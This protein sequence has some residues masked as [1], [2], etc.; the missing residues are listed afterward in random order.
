[1]NQ[2]QAQVQGALASLWKISG[3]REK[4]LFTLL[5]V[6]IY[7]FGVHVPMP[8]VDHE[9]LT[10]LFGAGNVL[11]GF[12]DL[13][14]GGAL[15]KFSVFALGITPYINASI[16]MQLMTSVIPKLEEL[17]K[18]GGEAGRKKIQ[19]WTRYFTIVLAAI[20]AIGIS[21]W[22]WASGVVLEHVPGKDPFPFMFFAANLVT[23]VAGTVFIMWLGELITE[24]GI[25]NGASLLIMISI[26]AAMPTYFNQ[27]AEGVSA[28][29]Y[30]WFQVGILAAAFLAILVAI[31]IVQEG[32]RRI[33]VQAAKRQ[34]G[35][36][37]HQGRMSYIPFKINQGGVMPIIFASSLML[38]PLTVSSWMGGAKPKLVPVDWQFWTAPAWNLDN[39][40]N[41]LVAALNGLMTAISTSGFVYNFLFFLLII[42]FTYF[43]ASLVL[44]PAEL[45]NNLKKY[46]NFIPG[47]RPGKPTAEFLEQVLNRITFLG[48]I[49]LGAVAIL[50]DIVGRATGILTFQGLGGTA[51]LIMVGVAIDLYNQLQTQLLSRQYEGF[52]K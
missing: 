2:A 52:M 40:K 28:G 21:N 50:P 5:M 51:L 17:Q 15:A 6:A 31:V 29:S 47:Y 1:M 36:R 23:L 27:T 13:F 41:A 44:N 10:G 25:G 37:I 4:I 19:Q 35:G 32:A 18:E 43:Y 39:I 49:F 46:G 3:L 38:F 8:G 7:R 33:P 12:L 42:F 22:L 14:S 16:I 48:A 30:N 34:V 20:Q 45:A 24:R 9:K 11:G 26:L